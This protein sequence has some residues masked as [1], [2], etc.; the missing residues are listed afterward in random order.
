MTSK[1]CLSLKSLDGIDFRLISKIVGNLEL[2]M[3]YLDFHSIEF[4]QISHY[5][6]Y[7][8]LKI[9]DLQQLY[10]IYSVIIKENLSSKILYDIDFKLIKYRNIDNI[11]LLDKINIIASIHNVK[12]DNI[13]HIIE[14]LKI[15]GNYNKITFIKVVIQDDLIKYNKNLLQRIYNYSKNLINKD[16]IIFFEG[17]NHT[18]SRYHSLLL[19]APF[20][21]C[22]LNKSTQTGKGQPTIDEAFKMINLLRSFCK[23][24]KPYYK[25]YPIG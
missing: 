6:E 22:A 5:F 15:L 12:Y 10:D 8:I 11:V 14:K 4:N 3:D 9:K 18:A 17:E 7:I 24:N 2:R 21:Y 19:G 23:N 16:L 13:I 20:I 25:K 1:I